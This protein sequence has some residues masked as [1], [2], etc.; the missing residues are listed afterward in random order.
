[1]IV[2]I[3]A[4]TPSVNASILPLCML[5]VPRLYMLSSVL[6]RVLSSAARTRTVD[7]PMRSI[8]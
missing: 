1:M 6:S 3:T 5:E 2:M 7:Q 4:I 8:G